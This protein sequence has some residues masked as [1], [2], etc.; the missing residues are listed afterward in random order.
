VINCRIDG[1]IKMI[2]DGEMKS[3]IKSI[4]DGKINRTINI[5]FN[6][7]INSKVNSNSKSSTDVNT[8]VTKSTPTGN[9]PAPTAMKNSKM[10]F[11]KKLTFLDFQ[12]Y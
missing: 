7:I 9:L 1:E 10:M 12:T 5:E 4:I 11:G 2:I 3:V 6:S 8:M